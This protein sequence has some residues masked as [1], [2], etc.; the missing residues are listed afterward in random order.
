MVEC[1][2][3][4]TV[5]RAVE[6]FPELLKKARR[7][8]DA[9]SAYRRALLSQWNLDN[10][11][12][13]RIQ[14]SFAAFLL[15]SGVE[16]SPPS[17][18]SQGSDSYTPKNNM[19]EAILLLMIIMRKLYQGKIKWDPSVLDLLTFALSI[20]SQTSVLA[21][22]L[23][24]FL[25]GVIHR[26][27]RWKYMAL[28]FSG[29][30]QN[31]YAL[32]LLRKILHPYEQPNDIISSLVASRLCNE[33]ACLAA[34]GVKYAQTVIANVQ[35]SNAHLKSVGL[36]MLG[37]CLGKQAKIST[38]DYERSRLQ[39]EALQ[40]LDSALS[41]EP[42]NLDLIFALGIHYAEHR[43]LDAALR[44]AKQY[45][46]ATGGSTIKGWRLLALVLSAQRRFSEADMVIEAALDETSKW[47]QGP[48]LR[49][50]VK[51]K[52]VQSLHKEAIDTYLI[53]LA[54]VQAQKKSSGS[55]GSEPQVE[56]DLQPS[57]I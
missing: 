55:S 51:L 24:E 16:A 8:P 11:C 12:Y 29:A 3:Q 22:Q 39:S 19:E 30:G 47:D 35:G 48:L 53:L 1:K 27:E 26:I 34:E 6:L 4:E 14:K 36:H 28:S 32:D 56:P 21:K 18:S 2:F 31:N 42:G 17:S 9:I 49:T 10:D 15:Y 43:N 25:P 37:L 54:L 7:Y 52:I 50:K 44:H 46:D 5:D 23:E 45:L 13:A 40:S 33:D 41:L 38:S 20:C 57:W